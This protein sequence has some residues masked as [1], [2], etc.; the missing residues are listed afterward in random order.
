MTLATAA[1]YRRGEPFEIRLTIMDGWADFVS[2]SSTATE[3][4]VPLKRSETP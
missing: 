2:D 1:G 3:T 4:A